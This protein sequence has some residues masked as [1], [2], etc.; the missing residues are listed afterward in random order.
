M[1]CP[2]CKGK[3]KIVKN[4]MDRVEYELFKCLKCGERILTS[5]QLKYLGD[6][7]KK[8]RQAKEVVFSKWG[9]S[10]AVRI[11]KDIVKEFK[12]NSGKQGLITKEKEGIKII[13]I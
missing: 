3:M 5:Q 11:P 9:N 4:K 1:K 6:Q 2:L 10:I 7:H 13:P 8:M 12:I